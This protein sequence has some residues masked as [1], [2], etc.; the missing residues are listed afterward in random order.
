[1]KK[2]YAKQYKGFRGIDMSNSPLEV[3]DRHAT[4][5]KNFVLERNLLAKRKGT[6]EIAKFVDKI[7]GCW[8]LKDGEDTHVL[9]HA[10][11]KIYRLVFGNSIND[12]T[13]IDLTL[14]NNAVNA[15]YIAD[16]RSFATEKNGNLYIVCGD[17]LC[18]KKV[19]DA[20]QLRRVYG[21]AYIPTTTISID[22]DGVDD[23]ARESFEA[24]NAFTPWRKNTLVGR[25]NAEATYTLDSEIKSGTNV[26]VTC[27][28]TPIENVT[29]DSEDASK[30]HF[31]CTDYASVAGESNLEVTFCVAGDYETENR[32]WSN[33]RIGTVHGE[34]GNVSRLF[35]SGN[36]NYR[37]VFYYSGINVYGVDDYSYF[38]VWYK[39]SVGY[40]SSAIGAFSKQNDGSLAIFKYGTQNNEPVV[41]YS[42]ATAKAVTVDTYALDGTVTDTEEVGIKVMFSSNA[43]LVG[44]QLA[45]KYACASLNG[46]NLFLATSGVYALE[47]IQN[48]ATAEKG[49]KLRSKP[50]A[51]LIATEQS[52]L[53]NAV[54][55]VYNNKYYLCIRNKVYMAD[56]LYAF[57]SQN[58]E[59][60]VL[61]NIS[62]RVFFE[63]DER[64]CYG[65]EDGRIIELNKQRMV[66][67]TYE[68]ENIAG[69]AYPDTEL[70][71]DYKNTMFVASAVEIHHRDLISLRGEVY[72]L[73]SNSITITNGKLS[74]EDNIKNGWTVYADGTLP[75]GMTKNTAYVVSGITE[76]AA[77]KTFLLYEV[78]SNE[79]L[80][81]TSATGLTL[82][83]K[84]D[85]LDLI[86]LSTSGNDIAEV[87]VGGGDSVK[88]FRVC[89]YSDTEPL[90]L[91]KYEGE[92]ASGIKAILI[93]DAEI[94]A[95]W[96]TGISDLGQ[97][98]MAKTLT[99]IFVT[100]E[101]TSD[102][103]ISFGVKTYST[104]EAFAVAGS[105]VFSFNNID[106]ANFTFSASVFPRG[107]HRYLMER[108]KNY[109]QF[110]LSSGST[111][112]ASV[113]NFS[114]KYTVNRMIK[115]EE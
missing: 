87:T 53:P 66:D 73:V 110:T 33:C 83:R 76:V 65:K 13:I 63:I 27:N 18:Y 55:Y 57:D 90:T 22:A 96:F 102:G 68:L 108:D 70:G 44:M 24:P 19:G 109:V 46:D 14:D 101:V 40:E 47:T 111:K 9:V 50:L 36:P 115:G 39:V 41:W 82:A 75:T 5:C 112:N 59:W 104:S 84:L 11:T 3:D 28:G 6:E 93:R 69:I 80:E 98:N 71:D 23:I 103:Q 54:G 77:P 15:S 31:N 52:N 74:T 92:S 42:T 114:V 35:I 12:Y 25:A 95:E 4:Q 34:N 10:G 100:P 26:T 8:T 79:P 29:V 2:V 49:A 17:L 38:P 62:A 1:M 88:P 78:G 7:N 64:L 20:Y 45:S 32:E 58:Y 94:V 106:F 85:G 91:Y 30:I 48:I 37:N 43:G 97:L 107:Y 21:D 16:E 61:D 51:S 99:D 89:E 56:A 86:A 81:I 72:M 67:R 105:T 113:N 60:W